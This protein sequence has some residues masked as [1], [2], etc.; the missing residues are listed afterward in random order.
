MWIG[1]PKGLSN[2]PSLPV[3]LS[4]YAPFLPQNCISKQLNSGRK[5]GVLGRPVGVEE[6]VATDLHGLTRMGQGENDAARFQ[7]LASL[8]VPLFLLRFPSATPREL[9]LRF[10]PSPR[11]VGARESWHNTGE[12]RRSDFMSSFGPIFAT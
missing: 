10:S 6:M 8:Q 11:I 7:R 1:L 12:R 9:Y 2:V 3:L 4:T 5:K